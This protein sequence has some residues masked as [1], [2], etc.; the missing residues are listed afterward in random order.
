M[1]SKPFQ[2]APIKDDPD[3]Y[4]RIEAAI[5]EFFK[6]EIFTP[7]MQ[8]MGHNGEKFKNA[9]NTDVPQALY[10]ALTSGRIT[11]NRGTFSGKFNATVSKELKRL[12]A[13]WDRK[14][15]TFKVPLTSLPRETR[16]VISA[17]D[18][19]FKEKIAKIDK[20]LASILPEEL[21]S[22]LKL[23]KM[24]D[25]TIWKV[26]RKFRENIKSVSI[27]AE[28]TSARRRK[29]ASEWQDNIELYIKDWTKEQIPKMRADLQKSVF[30]G[31]RWDSAIKVLQKHKT[32]SD[33]KAKFLARQ[34]SKL[35][36]AKF[37]E[38]RYADAG[39]R[40]Y[41]WHNVAGSP[42][43]PVRK[44][45]KFLGDESKKG[46]IFRF[47][48]PPNTAEE[49]QAPRYNNPGEDYNCRCYARAVVRFKK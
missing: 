29:I 49:G 24:F 1:P 35:L 5:R 9:K 2:L 39:I 46:A 10:D 21:V 15:G 19:R 23:E 7:A 26:D 20:K 8:A 12:G 45:H 38:S 25:S 13:E 17:T 18:S 3:Y 11:F 28:L 34:E 48:D 33:N 42:A 6:R 4:D 37:T 22:K 16:N 44:R 41:T 32:M 31:N 47:D 14:T 36:V 43:H 40:E 27:A 30:A